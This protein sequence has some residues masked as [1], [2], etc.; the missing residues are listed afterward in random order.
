MERGLISRQRWRWIP[1]AA[2]AIA[3]LVA[4]V[5]Y[6][7]GLHSNRGEL[8][9]AASARVHERS[10]IAFETSG[11]MHAVR[12]GSLACFET[13]PGGEQLV[14]PEGYSASLDLQLRDASGEVVATPDTAVGFVFGDTH[15]EAP[16]PCGSGPAR[17]VVRISGLRA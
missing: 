14:F 3:V 10:G 11:S 9:V 16:A 15:V 2:A 1:I 6:F 4:S 12:H 13:V 5:V 7:S 17:A 8:S